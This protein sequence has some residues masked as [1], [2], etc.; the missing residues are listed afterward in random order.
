MF[1]VAWVT[2]IFLTSVEFTKWNFVNNNYACIWFCIS[3]SL[4]CHLIIDR[5]AS[6]VETTHLY[7]LPALPWP[8][9]CL[10]QYISHNY[11]T[12]PVLFSVVNELIITSDS[13]CMTGVHVLFSMYP[14]IYQTL[15]IWFLASAN[16]Y[17]NMIIV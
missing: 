14:D 6:V 17:Y 12:I 1:L 3:C 8:V 10:F 9:S 15:S 11:G 13:D 2:T 16:Y 7:R 4:Y 5:W